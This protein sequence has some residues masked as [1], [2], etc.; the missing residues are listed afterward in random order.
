MKGIFTSL[1]V[2]LSLGAFSQEIL[3]KQNVQADSIRPTRGPNLRNFT[4]GYIGFGFPIHTNEV[5]N[6]TRT[7]TSID[8]D[9]GLRYKRR[10]TNYLA[11]G[12]DLGIITAAFKLK[13][14]SPKTVP[15]TVIND[16]EKIQISSLVSSGYVRI[17]VGRRGNYIG[18]YLDLGAYA[19]W[20][21]QK[22]HKTTNE[23]DE[24]E[25]VKVLTSKLNYVES[26]SYGLLARLGVSRYALTAQYR[27]SDIFK[28]SYAIPELP[29]LIVGVEVGLFK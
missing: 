2:L 24:G 11:A 7:G 27:L 15:D 16:K 29:R 10:I 20:N 3:L 13:Q 26:F 6:Y 1:L 23:N 17:N 19:G 5:L 4:Q 9:F 21:F 22:K 12:L 25:K 18:N 28:N 8:F 14:K